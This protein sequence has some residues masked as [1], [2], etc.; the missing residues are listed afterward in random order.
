MAQT[1]LIYDA[2]CPLCSA[3]TAWLMERT[4]AGA[5]ELLPCQSPERAARFPAIAEATCLEAVQVISPDGVVYAGERA[6][7]HLLRL[8]NGWRWFAW[9][10]AVPG[11]SLLAPFA[12]R[13]VAAHRHALSVLVAR[14]HPLPEDKR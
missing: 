3:A 2:Q 12:Y 11:V 9:V 14:K 10:F 13:W 7:P 1:T 5:I 6:L 4:P 8:M